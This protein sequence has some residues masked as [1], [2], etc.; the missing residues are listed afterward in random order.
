MREAKIILPKADNDGRKLDSLHN[1]LSRTL[2]AVFGGFTKATVYG[3]WFDEGKYFEDESWEYRIAMDN[4]PENVSK[5]ETLA[6]DLCE[7]ARQYAIYV[8]YPS[9]DV[10]I[11]NPSERRVAAE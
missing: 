10:S 8:V 11:L 4:T 3:G 5:V 9:G 1:L 6:Y 7:K 2:A